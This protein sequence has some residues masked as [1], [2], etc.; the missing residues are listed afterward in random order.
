MHAVNDTI[1]L[2]PV[3][4]K[5]TELCCLVLD[6]FLMDA[7]KM[8]SESLTTKDAGLLCLQPA[9]PHSVQ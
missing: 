4:K 2:K 6:L 8:N 7:W 3:N 9:C 1:S 5:C